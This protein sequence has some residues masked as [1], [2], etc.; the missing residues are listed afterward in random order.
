MA[1]EFIPA[2][3]LTPI[4]GLYEMFLIHHDENFKGSHW[5]SHG[6]ST[7]PTIIIG[8][9]IVFNVPLFLE[10]TNLGSVHSILGNAWV[11][12]A[13]I[14]LIIMIR[15]HAQ[16]AVVKTV[17]GSSKGLRETWLHTLIIAVLIVIAPLYWRLLEPL[18][19]SIIP[20]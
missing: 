13:V 8:L 14:G 7:F 3:I 1:F 16:S 5:F 11:I 15:I 2:L 6:L 19:R 12:R 20:I 18:V 9:L 17:A 10:W 4:L